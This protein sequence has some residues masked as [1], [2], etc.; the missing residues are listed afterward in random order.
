MPVLS[1]LVTV[2]AVNQAIEE[3]NRIG[4]NKFL[5][6]YGFKKSRDYF[7]RVENDLIDSKPI[8]GAAVGYARPDLG[9]LPHEEFSGG[10]A[11][12]VPVLK[13]LGYDLVDT[14]N[15]SPPELGDQYK[16]R[17][18]IH[19][20]YGGDLV[21]G[22]NR[23]PNENVANVFSDAEGPYADD[24]PVLTGMFGYRGQG[25]KGP[26]KVTA[27][28]DSYLE[29]ARLSRDAVRF[30]YRPAG[31]SFTFLTWAAVVGRSW[32]IGLD[33]DRSP[34]P[35]INWGIQS[36]PGPSLNIWPNDL[37]LAISEADNTSISDK[38]AP[39]ARPEAGYLELVNRIDSRG[40]ERR[41]NGVLRIDLP[42][43]SAARKAVLL[44]ADG[45]CESSRCTGMP[46]EVNRRGDPILDVD[47]IQDLALGGADH[48]LN[49]V[50]LCPNCHA[51]K[52]RSANV[53]VW[54]K[55]LK[56]IVRRAHAVAISQS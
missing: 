7:I 39:E 5:A 20:M 35:E 44:R 25:R 46:A 56:D 33:D 12:T 14:S 22:I 26:Q 28:G 49:M 10:L 16:N 55:E 45:V 51:C 50:A 4:R 52:T 18:A 41:P 9:P 31:G 38:T 24:P 21:G 8:L 1:D 19:K 53:A 37:L 6:K 29:Y 34:R 17:T 48:P 13:Q 54:R 36:V 11:E 30:W 15:A 40:Q 43:S 27:T 42:R 32:V 47:H 2:T 23:F 3:Y